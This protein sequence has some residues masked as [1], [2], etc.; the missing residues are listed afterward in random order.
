MGVL[1]STR[2]TGEIRAI[3]EAVAAAGGR[4]LVVGGWV[5]D[6][7]LG[8]DSKDVDV[9]VYGLEPE[10]LKEVLLALGRV[11]TVGE[12]F[13]VY[14]V[15]VRGGGREEIDVSVPRRE[16]KTGRGHRGFTV[17]GDPTMTVEEAARRRDFT[18]NAV[19]LDPLTGELIDPYGG[20]RDLE[21]RLLR[22]VDPETFVDDSLRVLRGAQFAARFRLAIDPATVALCRRIPLDD[23]P[24]ERVWGEMEK[25]LLLADEPSLGLEALRDL[26]VL[27]KLFP[28]LDALV[29][30]PQD[31]AWHPEGDVWTHTKMVCDEARAS[32]GDLSRAERTTVMLAA[33][34]H[35]LGKPATTERVDGRIRSKAHDQEGL[36]PTERLLDALNVHTI[37]GYDARTQ[38][39]ALVAEHLRPG[40]LHDARETVTDG[41]FRRLAR[42]VDC[43][44]LYLV[45]R[46]DALGRTGAARNAAAQEWFISRVRELGLEG[47]PPAP[48]LLGRHVLEL[49]IPPGPAVGRVT[50]AVYELQLDGRVRTLEEAIAAARELVASNQ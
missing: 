18:I 22:V 24:A 43:R 33:L 36:A 39:L 29:G 45:A 1:Y 42:R 6:R 14:K 4:A 23:L 7:L 8:F 19:M 49:G 2:V 17:E 5:R 50:K 13:T 26:G 10:R 25:L 11:N 12:S 48:L 20:A 21:A 16:S 41:A 27:P 9:E 15:R 30:C 31:P 38:V 35:D 37:D 32:I 34:C 46:S 28:E 40:Q 3:S 44:L 47:G